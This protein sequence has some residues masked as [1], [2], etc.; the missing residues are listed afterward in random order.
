MALWPGCLINK[1]G[2]LDGPGQPPSRLLAVRPP[3][4]RVEPSNPLPPRML[5]MLPH[6]QSN[7]IRVSALAALGG[8][9][10]P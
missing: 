4:D 5:G 8:G 10:P 7:W 3:Q 2:A 9:A 6:S 1:A